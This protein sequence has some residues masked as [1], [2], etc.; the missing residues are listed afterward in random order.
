MPTDQQTNIFNKI[1]LV[2]MIFIII[3]IIIALGIIFNE[4]GMRFLNSFKS[5]SGSLSPTTVIMWILLLV[6]FFVMIYFMLHTKNTV[7]VRPSATRST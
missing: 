1:V 4:G 3:L 6:V 5:N 7:Y 2:L